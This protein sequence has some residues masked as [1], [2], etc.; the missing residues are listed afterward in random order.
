[1]LAAEQADVDTI[2]NMPLKFA[3]PDEDDPAAE[4]ND[5][6]GALLG[7]HI[8]GPLVQEYEDH[9]R[10]LTKDVRVLKSTLQ[11]QTEIHRETMAEN[12]KLVQNLEVRQREYLKLLEETR[13]N[14]SILEQIQEEKSEAKAMQEGEGGDTTFRER[15]HLLTEENHILFE[16]VTLLRAHHD[17]FSKECA[18]KMTEAQDKIAAYD[19]LKGDFELTCRER[20]ELIKANSFLEMKL[21]QTTQLLAQLEGSRS[22]DHAETVKMR[23]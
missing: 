17:Q 11:Q 23:E 6:F 18:E 13:D 10:A 20:D 15:I 3:D 8:I 22:S 12:E 2:V 7:G 19:K 4:S 21:S 14:V 9:I 5:G 1:M 16:Q